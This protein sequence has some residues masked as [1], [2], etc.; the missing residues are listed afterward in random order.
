M[1][2]SLSSSLHAL[3]LDSQPLSGESAAVVQTTD[4]AK[5]ADKTLIEEE[6]KF[7]ELRAQSADNT[8]LMSP[9]KV[10]SNLIVLVVL[11]LVLAWLYKKYGKDALAKVAAAR[12][13]NK[14]A[15]N[16]LSSAS[17]GQGKYL[18]VI[19]VGGEKVLIGATANNISLLK[20]IKTEKVVS[21]E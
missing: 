21:D 17:V 19:E 14:D 12:P 8:A 18:H 10:F 15:I 3:A 1:A 16:V 6:K 4:I 13:V 2:F 9:V 11:L 7:Q 20:E 5:S